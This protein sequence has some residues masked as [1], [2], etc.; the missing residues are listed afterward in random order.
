MRKVFLD[1]DLL[2]VAVVGAGFMLLAALC[3]ARPQHQPNSKQEDS[4]KLFLQ[5]YLADSRSDERESTRYFPAFVDLKDGGTQEVIVYVTGRSW[6][7]SGGCRTLVL[8]PKGSSYEVVTHATIT[9]PPIRVLTTKSNGWHDISVWVQG[10]GIQP[11]YE[12]ELPFDGKTYPSNPS[13][14]PAR[15]I[16]QEIAGE[17]VIP[18]TG[19]G[20]PLY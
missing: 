19:K 16:V 14:P 1:F 6:C 18:L 3:F 17:V 2:M 20:I 11:G 9:R 5:D 15:R 12:A 4:L 10:G 8:A 7:G 13:V